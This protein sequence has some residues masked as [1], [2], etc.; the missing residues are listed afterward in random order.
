MTT[1]ERTKKTEAEE[2]QLDAEDRIYRYGY[3]KAL[4]VTIGLAEWDGPV[5]NRNWKILN[6]IKALSA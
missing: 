2:I 6:A 4:R 3:E 5:G 1:T